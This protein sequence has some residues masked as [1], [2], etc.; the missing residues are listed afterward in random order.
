MSQQASARTKDDDVLE[1]PF[2][3]DYAK[4]ALRMNFRAIVPLLKE[5]RLVSDPSESKS[6]CLS[7]LQLLYSSYEDSAILLHAFRNRIKGK[8]LHLTIGVEDQSRTG[9]TAMPQM[10][11]NFGFISLAYEK[12][13]QCFVFTKGNSMTVFV[14]LRTPSKA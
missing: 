6:I 4:F 9:S 13:S 5:A 3:Q 14:I 7:G 12:L 11:H 10:L 8:H 2:I 1:F